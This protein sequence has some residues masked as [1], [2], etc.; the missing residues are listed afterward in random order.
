MRPTRADQPASPQGT[1]G[2]LQDRTLRTHQCVLEKV[3]G[4][5]RFAVRGQSGEGTSPGE[6]QG[7]CHFGHLM[8]EPKQLFGVDFFIFYKL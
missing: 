5:A 1:S 3:P 8:A 4:E 7:G 2:G 6:G